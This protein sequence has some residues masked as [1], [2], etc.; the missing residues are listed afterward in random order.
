[1]P[2]LHHG[3]FILSSLLLGAC[4]AAEEDVPTETPEDELQARSE[5]H[6]FYAGALPR[7]DDAKITVSLKGHT[8]HVTGTLPAGKSIPS[9]PHVKTKPEGA[10]TRVDIVYPIATARPGKSNSRPGT[11]MFD[12]ARPY[13]PDG[14]AFTRDEGEHHVPWGGFPF[15]N[16][17]Q[18][19]AFHGPIT[20]ADNKAPK[21]MSVW[22]LERGPVSGGCNRMLGEHV[23]E[24]A[25][26]IG[27]PMSRIY[28][29]NR[30]YNTRTPPMNVTAKVDVIPDYDTYDGKFIDVDYPTA[31]SAV[32]PAR[33]HGDAKVVMFGSWIAT[34]TPDGSD[35]PKD[36]KWEGGVPG[37][38]YIF[39]EH[40]KPGLVC[41][42]SKG[43][44][45]ALKQVA[46]G[47]GG[48]IP[49][50]LCENRTCWLDNLKLGAAVATQR[51]GGR[52]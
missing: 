11:Y 6:Y 2:R 42:I 48:A 1:M 40:V 10:K 39:A 37:K 26:V 15:I 50:N 24:L 49:P 27:V 30:I 14:S 45:P 8:A 12:G 20:S 16:Y 4:S 19:I 22:Y 47:N 44:L 13:R 17:N 25:N 7:L 21:D 51:C 23:V 28:E 9:L 38:L 35:M 18:G 33:V 41:G 29:P 43:A 52:A 3:F 5:D 46:A 31:S 32:R 36:M 34:E